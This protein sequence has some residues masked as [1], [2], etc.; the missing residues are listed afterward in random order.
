MN[1]KRE[2]AIEIVGVWQFTPTAVLV[3]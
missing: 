2:I 3:N 1:V